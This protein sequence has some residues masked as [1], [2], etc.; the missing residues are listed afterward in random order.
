MGSAGKDTGSARS[1]FLMVLLFLI[2]RLFLLFSRQPASDVGIYADYAHQQAAA[3]RAGMSFYAYH[4]QLMNTVTA[5]AAQEQVEYPPLALAFL[6]LPTFWMPVGSPEEVLQSEFAQRYTAAYRAG[7][8]CVDVGMMILLVLLLGRLFPKESPQEHRQRLWLAVLAALALWYLLF[9]RLDLVLALLV[10]LALLLLL[11]RFPFG[12]ALALLAVAIHFKLVPVVLAPI[13]LVGSLPAGAGLTYAMP[14]LLAALALRTAVLALLIGG[15]L[16]PFTLVHGPQCLGFF[17]YHQTRGLEF[18]SLLGSFLLLCQPWTGPVEIAYTFKSVTVHSALAPCLI[19]AAPWIAGSV[20]AATSILFLSHFYLL[21]VRSERLPDQT[22]SLA[23]RYPHLIVCYSLLFLMLF[24]ATS[25]VFSPQYLLW[26]I[27]LVAL[28]P[29]GGNARRMFLGTFLLICVLSTLLFPFLFLSDLVA[30]GPPLPV[31]LWKFHPP[32]A[33]L[34]AVLV[35]RNT[36]LLGLIVGLF[37]HLLR[38]L[39][40]KSSTAEDA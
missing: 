12:W 29:L 7:L 24:I 8:A 11:S 34:T 17:T 1:W 4:A 26:L 21:L 19:Q 36:L 30:E 3:A 14:R 6:R 39:C 20:L 23:Q 38:C 25:K 18:E 2:S 35:L 22:A 16:L 40:I 33:R 37:A 27:P 13:F 31:V 28:V 9:D 32:S 5:P 10:L 15:L